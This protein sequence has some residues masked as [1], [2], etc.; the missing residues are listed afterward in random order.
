MVALLERYLV[1]LLKNPLS[2]HEHDACGP[3]MLKKRMVVL[4]HRELLHFSILSLFQI[5]QLA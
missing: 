3:S 5:G 1:S 2:K 4:I